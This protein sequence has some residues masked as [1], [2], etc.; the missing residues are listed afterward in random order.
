M[1]TQLEDALPGLEDNASAMRLHQLARMSM[2]LDPVGT[3]ELFHLANVSLTDAIWRFS[4]LVIGDARKMTRI[5]LDAFADRSRRDRIVQ[6]L[7]HPILGSAH[8][9]GRVARIG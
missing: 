6:L 2:T 4:V 8:M 5:D 7:D 9:C 3:Q 1:S